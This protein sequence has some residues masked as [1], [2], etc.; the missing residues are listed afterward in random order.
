MEQSAKDA[1][2]AFEAGRSDGLFTNQGYRMSAELFEEDA[3]KARETAERLAELL[4]AVDEA[5]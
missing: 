4:E 5:W 1:R 3:R 2:A